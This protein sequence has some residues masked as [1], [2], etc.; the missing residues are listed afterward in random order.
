MITVLILD[1][2]ELS[3]IQ[4][5]ILVFA[6]YSRAR[7]LNQFIVYLKFQNLS[8]RFILLSVNK[9]PIAQLLIGL[10]YSVFSQYFLSMVLRKI[11]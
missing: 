11:H 6:L 7:N 4:D 10:A 8:Q 3:I 9:Q 5:N 1:Q 2:T